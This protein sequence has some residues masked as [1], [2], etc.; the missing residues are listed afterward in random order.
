MAFS[1]IEGLYF[2]NTASQKK[3]LFFPNHTPVRLYTCGPTVYDYAHIGNFRTYVFEDILKRTLVF[4]GYSV[5]HVMNITDVEDKTIAGASK[6][7]IPLQEYTQPY[8]EAFFEDLDTL[9]IARAD[10]YPHATHYIPQMIQAITKLL[11]QGIAYIGQDASVYFSLNRFPNYGKLSHLDLSSLRCCSR[12]S[13]DEYDKENP[14]DFV[15]WKAY[16]PE[17]DGVIYWESPFGKG[18]PGWHLECSI[19]AMELLGDSLDIHAGGVDNIF[20]H[21]ENEIAQSEALSGKPFARYWLH[22]E[23]LLIDGK[24]MSK[25]LGNFL[26]LRDLLH[27]EFTGQEVRYMLLQSHYRTQLNFTEEALLACR[28]ALRRLKDFVSR[29]EGVDLPGESPLPRT[30]DSSS[31][32]IEAFSRALANDLN[33]STGFASLFDFVH[34]INTLIDQGHFSKAD[35]LY[36]LDTLKKVDTVLGVLPLT[37]SV[38]IPETVMQLVAEREEAR[39]TK[40]WAMAD[41]LRDEIL[42]AGFLVEDSKSGPKVKPL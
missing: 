21:H 37:T 22:S 11:E 1:H 33:V 4:F 10:F 35:S 29:L 41:T 8:T 16:N 18:R 6:K 23:H 20:P 24:K 5:T 12:I 14:S 30:L 25:S 39:K 28:H 13:A 3:E 2:Y 27:Q 9:N 26:T 32:F 42:A 36:I 15:L 31:Q 19:M 38:C 34:E 7:N 40:N 17:R